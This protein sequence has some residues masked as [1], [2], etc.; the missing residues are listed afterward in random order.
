MY[1]ALDLDHLPVGPVT[2]NKKDYHTGLT[3][4]HST[5]PNK[6]GQLGDY[7]KELSKRYVVLRDGNTIMLTYREAP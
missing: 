7:L 1:T 4:W 2:I 3:K 6:T 5:S